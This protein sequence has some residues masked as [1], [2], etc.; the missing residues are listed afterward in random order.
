MATTN[1]VTT[2]FSWTQEPE[3]MLRLRAAQ[4]TDAN[5]HQ[6]IMTYAGWCESR[7]ALEA[8]V[9]RYEQQAARV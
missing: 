9:V 8:H 5:Q 6:D 1:P 3:L 7:A 2:R 4:N